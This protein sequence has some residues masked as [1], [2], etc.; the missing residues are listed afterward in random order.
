[1][2]TLH[3]TQISKFEPFTE[4]FQNTMIGFHSRKIYKFKNKQISPKS[5]YFGYFSLR[6]WLYFCIVFICGIATSAYYDVKELI[7][8]SLF[9]PGHDLKKPNFWRVWS[10]ISLEVFI[11]FR[12]DIYHSNRLVT[13]NLKK[14]WRLCHVH[15]KTKHLNTIDLHVVDIQWHSRQYL[16]S[17]DI[18]LRSRQ[19]FSGLVYT[20]C[21]ERTE[22][23]FM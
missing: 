13:A 8:P 20:A 5:D 1:M 15:F 3:L 19:Y 21:Y 16:F 9:P 14:K 7:R 4:N 6:T 10:Q 23:I 11:H 2:P 18:K 17:V 12:Q 22:L